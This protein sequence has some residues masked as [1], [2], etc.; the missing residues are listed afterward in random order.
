MSLCVVRQNTGYGL[1][2]VTY[3]EILALVNLQGICYSEDID[4]IL[5]FVPALDAEYIDY[6]VKQQAKK[7]PKPK[8]GVK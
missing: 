6:H 1:L 8:K 5:F 3:Q 4:E 2:P 7:T